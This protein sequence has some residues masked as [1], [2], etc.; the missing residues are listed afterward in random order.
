MAALCLLP[1]A[2]TAENAPP[3]PAKPSSKPKTTVEEIKEI[4]LGIVGVMD[5]MV[6]AL[7]K[8]K[9]KESAELAA[10]EIT[11]ATKTL[12][13]LATAGKKLKA[14]ATESDKL[15]LA[16]TDQEQFSMKNIKV[17]SEK[18]FAALS[19]KPELLA[20]LQPALTAFSTATRAMY[21]DAA[22]AS[23]APIRARDKMPDAE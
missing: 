9:D 2:V 12:N 18:A 7:E 15:E 6:S 13:E 21:L 22:A 14:K 23:P 10:Q 16:K 20:I 1:V 3:P 8:A 17:R 19:E 4:T 11:A 5:K